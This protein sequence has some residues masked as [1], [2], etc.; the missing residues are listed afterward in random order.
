MSHFR[1]RPL[2]AFVSGVA[3]ISLLGGCAEPTA[4][5]QSHALS[6]PRADGTDSTQLSDSTSVRDSTRRYPTQPWY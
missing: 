5:A 2:L 6:A 4:P 3:C 1:T